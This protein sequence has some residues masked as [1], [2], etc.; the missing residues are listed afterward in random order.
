M[1]PNISELTPFVSMYTIEWFKRKQWVDFFDLL[2]IG[3]IEYKGMSFR[4][5]EYYVK[6]DFH[7]RR[8]Q[9]GYVLRGKNWLLYDIEEYIRR[10]RSRYGE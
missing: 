5:G 3:G 8:F 2:R 7:E 6:Y 9:D 1:K 10:V 4:L